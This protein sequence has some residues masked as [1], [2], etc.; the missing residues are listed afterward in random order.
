MIG[1]SGAMGATGSGGTCSSDAGA[2]PNP[3]LVSVPKLTASAAKAAKRQRR[4]RVSRTTLALFTFRAPLGKFNTMAA[5]A[6][7]ASDAGEQCGCLT[8]KTVD[9]RV[10]SRDP[11]ERLQKRL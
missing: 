2:L 8:R 9:A 1:V 5:S 4:L 11:L 7:R 10:A 3:Q 6:P